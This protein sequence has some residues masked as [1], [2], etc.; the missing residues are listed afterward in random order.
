MYN[1]PLTIETDAKGDE[2]LKY[3][4]LVGPEDIPQCVS[5]FDCPRQDGQWRFACGIALIGEKFYN[6]CVMRNVCQ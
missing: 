3:A 5:N 4:E 1:E 2:V 6:H